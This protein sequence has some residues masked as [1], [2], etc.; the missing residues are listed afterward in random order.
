MF[1]LLLCL[2]SSVFY[3]NETFDLDYVVCLVW[4]SFVLLLTATQFRIFPLKK[5]FTIDVGT[6]FNNSNNLRTVFT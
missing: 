2:V 1:L 5:M 6:L 3:R 4:F